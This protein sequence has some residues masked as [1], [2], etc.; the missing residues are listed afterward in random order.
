MELILKETIDTLGEEGDVVKVKPGYGRNYLVPQGK[1]VQ[2]TKA[3]IA[4]LEQQMSTIKARKEKERL[5]AEELSKKISGATVVI[6]QRVGEEDKLYGSVTSADIAEKLAG[7]GIVIDKR[8]IILDEPIKTLGETMVT[9]KTG[10][11]MTSEVKV[12]IVPISIEE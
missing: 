7:L 11:Q 3:N 2:A 5:A 4:I 6:E 8:K 10:Y 9:C 12:E 1:A